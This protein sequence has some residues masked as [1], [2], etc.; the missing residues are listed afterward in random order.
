M[1]NDRSNE[2]Y[3]KARHAELM[4]VAQHQRLM[5]EA[6]ASQPRAERF[7]IRMYHLALAWFGRNLVTFS[8][9]LRPKTKFPPQVNRGYQHRL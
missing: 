8:Q 5:A 9:G 7:H 2:L 6:Q 1:L 3:V 4:Q